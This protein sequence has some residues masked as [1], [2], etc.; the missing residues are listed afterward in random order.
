[1]EESDK[2]GLEEV[3]LESYA[4]VKSEIPKACFKDIK[5]LEFA[6][7][8]DDYTYKFMARMRGTQ[9]LMNTGFDCYFV[10][11]DSL[12][13]KKADFGFGIF[14]LANCF[15]NGEYML[16]GLLGKMAILR[17]LQHIGIIE[18]HAKRE[19]CKNHQTIYGRYAQ[20][21]GQ[22]V[23][24]VGR[25][26]G[27]YRIEW[28]DIQ[29]CIDHKELI[30]SDVQH[31][32]VDKILGMAIVDTVGTLYLDNEV[33]V[34]LTKVNTEAKWTI[35]TCLA[36]SWIVSG[37]LYLDYDGLAIVSSIS[38]KGDVK[39]TLKLKLTSNGYQNRDGIVR[40]AGIYALRKVYVTG[41]RGIMMAIERDGCCHLISVDYGRLSVLQSIDSI[42]PSVVKYE[43]FRLVTS[44]TATAKRGQFIFGG[45]NWTKLI[46]VKY[47]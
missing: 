38:E 2:F 5:D 26:E 23:Y 46:T 21:A 36:K 3:C 24:A 33:E 29:K 47:K 9:Y 13:A 16:V 6:G 17:G 27:L 43:S 28:K 18:F 30:R 35:V 19:S 15:I 41:M 39:S 11:I 25:D 45:Y 14:N 1:M 34:D 4:P 42:V 32:F 40:F 12:T 8:P 44:V 22:T 31:F 10:D 37:D 7:M 20:Q